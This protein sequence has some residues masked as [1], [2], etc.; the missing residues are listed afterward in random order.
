M[1][2]TKKIS[3]G[4]L[5]GVIIISIVYFIILFECYK[6]QTFVFA[7]YQRPP[8]PDSM[9][10]FFPLGTITP[11]SPELYQERNQYINDYLNTAT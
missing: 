5:V 3:V 10:P 2:D 1:V 11:M 7:P 9:K 6:Q 8:P 4:I